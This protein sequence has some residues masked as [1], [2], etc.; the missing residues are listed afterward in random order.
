VVPNPTLQDNHQEELAEVLQEE[1][2]A[3]WSD[4]RY[5]ILAPGPFLIITD[6]LEEKCPLLSSELRL[7]GPRC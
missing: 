1:G 6:L 4:Y 5:D 3:I 7:C 2:Y